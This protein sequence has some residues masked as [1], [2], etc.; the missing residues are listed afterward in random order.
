VYQ[1]ITVLQPQDTVED[2]SESSS[3]SEVGS[4]FVDSSWT[5]DESPEN[6][7]VSLSSPASCSEDMSPAFQE[8]ACV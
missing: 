1:T 4:I 8:D 3:S 5:R 7:K 6:K 2:G